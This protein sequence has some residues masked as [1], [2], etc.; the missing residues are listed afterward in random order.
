ML[1]QLGVVTTHLA[2]GW[3]VLLQN[4]PDHAADSTHSI[5]KDVDR[6]RA[7]NCSA[8]LDRL[9][10]NGTSGSDHIN[11]RKQFYNLMNEY[12]SRLSR[13]GFM[14]NIGKEYSAEPEIEL[15]NEMADSLYFGLSART[16]NK[17]NS[18]EILSSRHS[19]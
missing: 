13:E 17:W 6:S 12:E 18:A 5:Q 10:S 19:N 2:P 16:L 1:C 7:S 11:F 4:V 15:I 8:V 14:V 3:P 9:I